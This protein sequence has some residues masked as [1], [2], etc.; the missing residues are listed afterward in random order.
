MIDRIVARKPECGGKYAGLGEDILPLGKAVHRDQ[1]T[2]TATHDT[3]G[4]ASGKGTVVGVNIRFE[5]ADEEF[6]IFVALTAA[7]LRID[8]GEY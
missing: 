8:P 4:I 1:S 7:V 2:H 5:R 6:D 3:G